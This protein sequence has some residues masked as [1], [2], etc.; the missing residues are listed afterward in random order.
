MSAHGK[1]TV[2]ILAPAPE[3]EHGVCGTYTVLIDGVTRLLHRVDRRV[4]WGGRAQPCHRQP[5]E[6]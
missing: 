3:R 2:N 5:Q 4:R 6:L 1:C